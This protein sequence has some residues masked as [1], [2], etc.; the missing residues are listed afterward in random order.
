MKR[1]SRTPEKVAQMAR[2][3]RLYRRGQ[4]DVVLGIERRVCGCD[5]GG[6]SWSTREESDRL[7]QLLALTHGKH[8]LE[9]GAGSGWPGLY[10]AKTSGCD[11]T[12]TDLLPD[13]LQIAA[14]RAARD[15]VKGVTGTHH[16]TV[17]DGAALPFAAGVFDAVVH[18]DVLCCLEE[19]AATLSA[20][21]RVIADDGRMA[22]S[23][24]LTTPGLTGDDLT[25]AIA[26]GPTYVAAAVEYPDMVRQEG[27]KIDSIDD[28]TPQ[29]AK[30]LEHMLCE[31][32]AY[33]NELRPLVGEPDFSDRLT[34][35]RNGLA[36]LARGWQCQS[37][38]A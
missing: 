15:Q 30:T 36:A 16:F 23:V 28:I 14:Q 31:E 21:R 5:Y 27:W 18:S 7:C 9:I 20:C 25:Q 19:K 29:Y 2:F 26:A 6:T 11:I 10:L 12:L 24:I 13:S 35:R 37:K 38:L 3:S 1:T 17:A 22:F 4:S 8:L 34:K 33:A 32:E